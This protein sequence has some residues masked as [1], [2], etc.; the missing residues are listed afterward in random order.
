MTEGS[1]V[2]KAQG[3]YVP[4]TDLLGPLMYFPF[5]C[6]EIK[7]REIYASPIIATINDRGKSNTVQDHLIDQV[8]EHFNGMSTLMKTINSDSGLKG[9]IDSSLDSAKKASWQ[10]LEM[11]AMMQAYDNTVNAMSGKNRG[12]GDLKI[13]DM[14]FKNKAFDSK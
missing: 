5:H 9:L 6:S 8:L 4:M 10:V 1:A 11:E 3:G 12:I 13:P 14:K 7:S 2:Y